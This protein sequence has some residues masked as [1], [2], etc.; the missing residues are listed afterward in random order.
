M[1]REAA[2]AAS[3]VLV[4]VEEIVDRLPPMM[5]AIVLPHWVVTAVSH[6]P[7]G[8]YPSYAQ[9]HYTRDNA[10]YR[11]WDEIARTRESFLAWMQ[12]HVLE[13]ADHGEFIA[14]LQR[15]AA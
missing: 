13:T 9:G 15:K 14:S 2:L 3:A 1:Q 11:Q 10:F 5:N 12:R 7:A 8:A 6:C 4:T